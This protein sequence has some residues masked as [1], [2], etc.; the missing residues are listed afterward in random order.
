M[1]YEIFDR[2][3]DC[4]RIPTDFS[5]G[6]WRPEENHP[7]DADGNWVGYAKSELTSTQLLE[8]QVLFNI[9]I[10]LFQI[11]RTKPGWV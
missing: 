1:S 8:A 6:V 10:G 5:W 7:R 2:L 11:H 3:R 9:D 4:A